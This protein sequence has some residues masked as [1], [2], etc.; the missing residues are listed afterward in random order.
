M[1]LIEKSYEKKAL[2]DLPPN[3]RDVAED[4]LTRCSLAQLLA[5][6]AQGTPSEAE[7][8]LLHEHHAPVHHWMNILKA[9]L[10]A[11]CTY[12]LPSK[13]MSQAQIL[14]LIKCACTNADYPLGEY[15]L[16]D[17]IEISRPDMLAFSEWLSHMT[18]L[19]IDKKKT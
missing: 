2:L 1:H 18:N 7:Q 13:D 8:R 14:Y 9:T 17:I 16:A 15:S 11:K 3:A 4:L 10:L 12:F 19:L 5:L 6:Q